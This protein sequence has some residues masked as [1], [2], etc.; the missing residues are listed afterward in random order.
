MS[1]FP[2]FLSYL[3]A[4][5]FYPGPHLIVMGSFLD[6]FPSAHQVLLQSSVFLHTN[7]LRGENFG[8]GSNRGG[9]GGKDK[10]VHIYGISAEP[11]ILKDVIHTQRQRAMQS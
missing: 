11:V 2:R 7:K 3:K 1:C 6:H 10:L 4:V 5:S 9:G 8:R